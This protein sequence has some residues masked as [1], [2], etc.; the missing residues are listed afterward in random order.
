MFQYEQTCM[1]KSRMFLIQTYQTLRVTI[2][3][4]T[5]TL[6][7]TYKQ[8]SAVYILTYWFAFAITHAN[9]VADS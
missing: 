2:A 6:I 3:L 7:T 1:L 9:C 8:T 4:N 5:F